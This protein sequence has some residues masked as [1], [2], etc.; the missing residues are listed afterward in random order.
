MNALAR[1]LPPEDKLASPA[2]ERFTM[3]SKIFL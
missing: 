1:N 2:I 3:L